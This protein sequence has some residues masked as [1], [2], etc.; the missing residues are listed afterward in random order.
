M[1]YPRILDGEAFWDIRGSNGF[2]GL[3]TGGKGGE[4]GEG[5]RAFRARFSRLRWGV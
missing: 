2:C 4:G 1:F 5:G 3:Y